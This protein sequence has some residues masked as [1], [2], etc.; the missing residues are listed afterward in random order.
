MYDICC[1]GHITSDRIVNSQ[2]VRDMPGGTAIY[3]SCAL[4]KFD[5]QYLLITSLGAAETYYANGLATIG[6]EVQVQPGAHTVYFE[7]IYGGNQDE[8][9]QNVLQKADPFTIEQVNAVNAKL[10]HLGPLLA[11][12]MSPQF[13]Q[14]LTGKGRISLD[15]QG[16]LRKVADRKV[17]ATDWPG[18]TEV[19]PYVDILKADVGELQALTGCGGVRDGIRQVAAFG[20]KE[21]VITNGSKGSLIYADDQ[22]YTIP[23]YTSGYMIDATGCGD[24]YM[25]G[26]LYQRIKGM[27][28]QQAGEFAAAMSGLKTTSS[29]PFLGGEEEVISFLSH[30]K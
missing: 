17:Y 29:G 10:F 3:F 25:A 16:Y 12:D 23:A 1:I 21:I 14:S 24:T 8:R 7:N 15:V 2:G 26:Y 11:D 19:L 6:I 18:K 9:T 13:V 4:S 30:Q 5:L 28:I 20:V 27:G 22:F